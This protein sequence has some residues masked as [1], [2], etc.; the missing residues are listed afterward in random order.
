[1]PGVRKPV[2]HI[3]IIGG[4]PAGATAAER[5]LAP[6]SGRTSGDIR[7]TV[8]EEKQGW[9]KPCGGGLPWKALE[10]YPFLLEAT[11]EHRLVR[12]AELVAGDGRA[13]RFSLRR[14]LAIYSR[15]TLNQLLLRRAVHAGAEIVADRVVGVCRDRGGWRLRGSSRFHRGKQADY[16]A[17]YVIL[18][19]GARSALRG[20]FAP[21][22]AP[23]DFML[24]FGY[25]APL[26]APDGSVRERGLDRLLRVQFFEDFEG[27]AWAFPRPDHLSLGICGKAGENRM[28]ALQERL[29]AFMETFGY[30][31]GHSRARGNPVFSHLLPALSPD[32]WSAM[33]L[34]GDGWAMV[35]DAAG[36]VDPVTG[37]GIYF[38]MRSGELLAES[39]RAASFNGDSAPRYADRVREDF[40]RRLALGARLA[41]LFYHGDFLGQPSTTR[42]VQ[43]AARSAAFAGL[44][45]DLI[46]GSQSYSGLASRLYRGFG[47][48]V[49]GTVVGA[50]RDRLKGA[51]TAEN[52]EAAEKPRAAA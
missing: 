48:A 14:P 21:P 50:I 11:D 45:Q 47:R 36:L 46:E 29:R 52:T 31:H 5:L 1:M 6:N 30:G 51:V 13:V 15:A 12:E 24:T 3:A 34:A 19:A 42:L 41:P 18:A 8:F 2:K 26:D 17:D 10:R 44:L 9:E 20:S 4:G 32:G 37:E 43:F 39:L 7:V 23:R 28:S 27:Y 25:Y 49:A 22:F 33:R 38:A 35:G 40:G 16:T